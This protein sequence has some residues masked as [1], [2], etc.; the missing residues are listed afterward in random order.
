[1]T[2]GAVID[3]SVLIN[4]DNVGELASLLAK[5]CWSFA[6]TDEVVGE[7]DNELKCAIEGFT[8]NGFISV[9]TLSENSEEL[10]LQLLAN[11]RIGIGE[12]SAIAYAKELGA[13]FCCDDKKARRVGA[14]ELGS[15][16]VI[17]TLGLIKRA[18]LRGD[19]TCAMAVNINLE[20]IRLGG[21]MPAQPASYFCKS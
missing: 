21:Y 13:V 19:Y 9:A 5:D 8:G 16:R 3:T 14:D 17:G 7:C 1:M 6:V 10:S 4:T 18:V 12:A 15:Q 2:E 11:M 20:M